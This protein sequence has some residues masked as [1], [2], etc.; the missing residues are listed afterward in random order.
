MINVL[1]IGNKLN[2]K[3]TNT[4]SIDIL[5][6]LLESE[7][8]KLYYASTVHNKF[9]RLLDMVFKTIRYAYKIDVVLIDT[10]STQNFYYAFAV[11]QV[12]KLL[13]L[14]YIPILRGGN[15]E[16]RLKFSPRLCQAIFTKA[17]VMVAPSVYIRDLFQRFDYLDVV[18]VP[19][20]IPIQ[21][22]RFQ[23]KTV[24]TV[25]LLWVRAFST[26]YNPQLAVSLLKVL[27]E[28]GLDASLCMVG[29]DSDGSFK[30]VEQLVNDLQ[31]PVRLTGKLSKTEW[32]N[33]ATDYNVFV[34]TTNFDNMPVSVIEAMALG[35]PIVST[36]VGGM[37]YLIDD[38][39][40]GLLVPPN[41]A[42]AMANAIKRIMNNPETTKTMTFN[43]RKKAERFAWEV[44]KHQW[45]EVLR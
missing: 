28:D 19:N 6:P 11:S 14:K 13:N 35:L 7:G 22:Y 39:K 2:H 33:L 31:V 25:K 37:P 27:R 8:F 34:N 23:P 17:K 41:D 24:D 12:C 32:T 40:D 10:Y 15:L 18:Y 16:R 9:F 29:P 1:Y 38:G 30:K 21:Q 44:V 36:N 3:Q 26:I 43:A 4:T 20:S 45:F 42:K 5:G